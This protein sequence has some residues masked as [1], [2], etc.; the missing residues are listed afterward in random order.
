M[1]YGGSRNNNLNEGSNFKVWEFSNNSHILVI[2]EEK[3]VLRNPKENIEFD[4]NE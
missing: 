3:F 1:A 2:N 4:K